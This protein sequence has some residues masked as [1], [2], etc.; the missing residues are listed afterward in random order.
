MLPVC[1][2]LHT[3]QRL[4]KMSLNAAAEQKERSLRY[5]L[6]VVKRVLCLS[7]V[8]IRGEALEI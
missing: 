1:S 3:S 2:P 4:E 7:E 5:E 6:A 8:K